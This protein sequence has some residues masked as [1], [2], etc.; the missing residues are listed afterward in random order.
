M[1]R[2]LLSTILIHV[3]ALKIIVYAA[4]YGIQINIGHYIL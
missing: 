1:H 4:N 3:Y 2:I